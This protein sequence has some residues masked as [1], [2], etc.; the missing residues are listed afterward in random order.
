MPNLFQKKDKGEEIM[1][2]K[3]TAFYMVPNNIALYP[4]YLKYHKHIITTNEEP[5]SM[6]SKQVQVTKMYH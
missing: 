2:E 1:V 6:A 3:N 4:I 5:G